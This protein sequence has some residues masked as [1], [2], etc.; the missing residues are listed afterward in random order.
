MRRRLCAAGTVTPDPR[1][2]K[3][4]DAILRQQQPDGTWPGGFHGLAQPGTGKKTLTTEQ[5]L[6]RLHVLGFTAADEPIRRCLDT[7]AACLRGER[8]IDSYWETGIDWAMYEPLMLAAWIR[9]YDPEQPDALAFASRWARVAEAGFSG[10]SHDSDAWNA[11]C[12]AEFHRAARHPRPLGFSAL[13]HTMLLP[14]LLSPTTEAALVR[15]VLH[16]GM[17]YIHERPLTPPPACFQ[18]RETSRWLAALSLLTAY[19]AARE[20]L[21]FAKVWLHLNARPD[22]AWDMGAACADRVYL[23][24]ADSWRSEAVRAADCTSYVRRALALLHDT[25]VSQQPPAPL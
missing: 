17:Y 11:A 22:G 24:L 23:P 7:M 21:A 10:G 15:H 3:W 4:A 20:E 18:S 13:Y 16:T 1:S 5:A 2:G 9:L 19:P 8:K 6:R 25:S 12:E 14:G